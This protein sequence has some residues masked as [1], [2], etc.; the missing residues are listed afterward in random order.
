M[1]IWPRSQ[2]NINV[3]VTQANINVIVMFNFRRGFDL[4]LKT[5][6]RRDGTLSRMRTEK[7]CSKKKNSLM[8]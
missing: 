1:V 5:V 2:A 7:L 4:I 3:I 8:K 6:H